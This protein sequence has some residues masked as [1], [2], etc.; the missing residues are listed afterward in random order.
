MLEEL[1]EIFWM[2]F[3]MGQNLAKRRG[4]LDPK[5][6]LGLAATFIT[7]FIAMMIVSIIEPETSANIAENS[8]LS[9]PYQDFVSYAGKS[10]KMWGLAIFIGVLGLI[11]GS[12]Y[13][14]WK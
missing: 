2:Y 3:W 8:S 5:I 4:A 9:Q 1:K 11:L 13:A 6:G 14:F 12:I 10:F 7:A